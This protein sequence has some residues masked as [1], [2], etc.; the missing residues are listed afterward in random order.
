MWIVQTLRRRLQN[1]K[2]FQGEK[3]VDVCYAKH[4]RKI[5]KNKRLIY[6]ILIVSLAVTT[7]APTLTRSIT[8]YATNIS[9]IQNQIHAH[10][11]EL[12]VV[13]EQIE[14]LNDEQDLLQELI[15]D[16]NAEII[17][18]MASIGL[19][20]DGIIAKQEALAAKQK[21]LDVKQVEIDKT[22]TAYEEA[23]AREEQ[24]YADMLVW[25]KCM[26]ENSNLTYLGVFLRGNGLGDMLNHMDYIEKV[27]EYGMNKLDEYEATK[28]QVKD[29]WHMLEIERALLEQE[30]EQLTADKLQLEAD[31]EAL[32]TQKQELDVM[33]EKKKQ[34]S[35]NYE[36]EINRY[37]QEAAVMQTLLEQ[38][39]QQLQQLQAQQNQGNT[40]AANG[41]Y[42]ST[43]YT[44]TIDNASGSDM[45]KRVAKYACQYIGNP[46]VY[47]GTSLTNGADC[48][49]FVYRIYKDFGYNLPRTSYEQRSAG[50]EVNY[51][52]AQPGDLICYSGHIGIYIGDGKIVHASNSNPYPRGGIK[53]NNA[54]YRTILAVRRIV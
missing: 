4:M 45:G 10:E 19:K 37:K 14:A 18:T 51:S 3:S 44:S 24:Q 7:A 43:S 13:N 46:Y 5:V 41:S 34:E 9:D 38:E 36:A 39:R 40:P 22:H 29:L 28:I 21:E 53:V 47:G 20:E 15:D 54:N 26:Y 52:D 30:K 49:G 11:N 35:A 12:E 25:I 6:F 23:K 50:K 27:Y 42:T 16:L 8:A 17:N 31:R 2:Y 33:L 48:S 32:Q 1:L